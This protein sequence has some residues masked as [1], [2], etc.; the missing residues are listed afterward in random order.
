MLLRVVT[1]ALSIL[2][3]SNDAMALDVTG[4]WKGNFTCS[5]FNGK[6]FNYTDKNHILK[7]TQTNNDLVVKW[8]NENTNFTGFVIDDQQLPDTKG[9]LAFANCKTQADLTTDS[10]LAQLNVS[11]NRI[12]RNGTL[13][14]ISIYTLPADNTGN[15]N[16][17]GQCKWNFKLIDIADP[18]VTNSCQ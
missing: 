9:Q 3:I 13:T 12:K 15:T 7:I 8:T 14:G 2:M 16:V 1:I 17:V 4:T 6:K 5:G 10:E 11:I 18:E